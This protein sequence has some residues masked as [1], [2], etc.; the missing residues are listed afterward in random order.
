MVFI[1]LTRVTTDRHRLYFCLDLFKA[2]VA[3]PPLAEH[4]N[5]AV[6]STY[7]C[8]HAVSSVVQFIVAPVLVGLL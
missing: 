4:V 6:K 3:A 2:A 1:Q 8:R 7:F 5:Y